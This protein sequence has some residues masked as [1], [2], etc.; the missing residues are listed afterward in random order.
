MK[1]RKRR[2]RW[3][4]SHP[5]ST[6][7]K[8]ATVGT[9]RVNLTSRARQKRRNAIFKKKKN[10]DKRHLSVS[11]FTIRFPLGHKA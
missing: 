4:H 8:D 9:R 2:Q 5:H 6:W 7:R 1:A 10:K 3:I 11:F